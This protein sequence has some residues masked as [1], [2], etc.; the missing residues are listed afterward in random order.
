MF[1]RRFIVNTVERLIGRS[2]KNRCGNGGKKLAIEKTPERGEL[3]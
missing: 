2:G 3:K 1:L